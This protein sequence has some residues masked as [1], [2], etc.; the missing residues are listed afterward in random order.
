MEVIYALLLSG[1]FWLLW[2]IEDRLRD[3]VYAI[4]GIPFNNDQKGD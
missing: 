3:I 4:R 1:I 2:C